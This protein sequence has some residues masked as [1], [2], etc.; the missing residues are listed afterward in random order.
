MPGGDK[1]A[2]GFAAQQSALVQGL[3]AQQQHT[4]H[5]LNQRVETEVQVGCCAVVVAG[6]QAVAIARSPPCH[7]TTGPGQ[8]ADSAA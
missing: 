8:A 6:F 5:E 4:W 2:A 1:G 7:C 3:P